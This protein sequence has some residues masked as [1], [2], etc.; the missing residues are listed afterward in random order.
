MRA[1]TANREMVPKMGRGTEWEI[2]H[3]P[4]RIQEQI[5]GRDVIQLKALD[6][7]RYRP[8]EKYRPIEVMTLDAKRMGCSMKSL[9]ECSRS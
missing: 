8:R 9:G 2:I 5:S 3:R 1:H 7:K 6:V 4:S